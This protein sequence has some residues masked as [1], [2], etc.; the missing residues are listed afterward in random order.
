MVSFIGVPAFAGM[1]GFG[2]PDL[3]ESKLN[4]ERK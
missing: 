2:R 1:S 4:K 3:D